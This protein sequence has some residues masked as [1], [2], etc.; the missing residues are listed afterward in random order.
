MT[1]NSETG[2]HDACPA[3]LLLKKLSGRF[4]PE[5]FRLAMN[6]PVRFNRLLRQL[7]GANK[8]SVATALRELHAAGLLEKT[9]ITPKPLHVEY[10]LSESGRSL[11]TVF[12]QLEQLS[13][14]LGS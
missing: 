12:I 14:G 4:K 2:G 1:T 13:I 7:A 6:G 11:T 5:I 10:A 9:V 8:Q 3:A